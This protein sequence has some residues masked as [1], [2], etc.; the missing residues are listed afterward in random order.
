MSGTKGV[1]FNRNNKYDIQLSA[2]LIAERKLADV[3]AF[4]TFATKIELKTETYQW[5]R[6]GNIAVEYACDGKPS[7]LAVTEAGYWVH[8]LRDD[9]GAT[10][11]YL[12]V[13]IQRLKEL[14][15]TE[16]RKGNHRRGGDDGRFE[17]VIINVVDLLTLATG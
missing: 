8:E 12:M 3:F 13:P 5:R 15:A 17:M 11:L 14:A 10:V 7:G 16:Y 2:A 4:G 1:S 9:D 6:T